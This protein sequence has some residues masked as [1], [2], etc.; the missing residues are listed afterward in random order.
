[1]STVL[2][3]F[4]LKPVFHPSGLDRPVRFDA[5]FWTGS[6]NTKFYN[7]ATT[8]YAFQPVTIS[9]TGVIDAA[10]QAGAGTTASQIYGVFLGAEYNTG[11]GERRVSKYY[12]DGFAST[13]GDAQVVF[14]IETDPDMVYEVQAEGPVANGAVGGEFNFSATAGRTTGAG[15]IIGTGGGSGFSTTAISNTEVASAAQG[16]VRCVGI[17]RAFSPGNTLN[18]WGDAFTVLQVKIA[19]NSF[20][21][22][23]TN[24]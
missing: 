8:F 21:A 24:L 11:T 14:I 2:Q 9:A 18:L 15:T 17:G 13:S 10:A 5:T 12:Q 7:T 20:V 16:Q 6:A 22:P 4:G 1:M 19:N 3:P 23:K